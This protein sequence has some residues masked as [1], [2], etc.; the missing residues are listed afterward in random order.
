MSQLVGP[1][2]RERV[3]RL[4][5]ELP[6]LLDRLPAPLVRDALRESGL[7]LEGQRDQVRVLDGPEQVALGLRGEL[8]LGLGARR[9]AVLARVLA[10]CH[11]LAGAR[12]VGLDV[13]D[14]YLHAVLLALTRVGH[15]D[16]A[17]QRGE[18]R[19]VQL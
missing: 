13:Q 10:R 9:A 14:E 11:G 19:R 18:E 15:L 17:V 1:L 7:T 5:R 4:P 2:D 12:E 16:V 3:A 8:E 6:D